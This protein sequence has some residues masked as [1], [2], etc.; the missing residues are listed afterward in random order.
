MG[1]A[2][3][4]ARVHHCHVP[5][6]TFGGLDLLLQEAAQGRSTEIGRDLLDDVLKRKKP[7]L[8]KL[9]GDDDFVDLIDRLADKTNNLKELRPR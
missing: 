8:E 4:Q 5:A 7:Y 1:R 2:Q 3:A 6:A 9:C